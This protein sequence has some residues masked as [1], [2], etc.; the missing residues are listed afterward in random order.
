MD[1][2]EPDYVIPKLIEIIPQLRAR[3]IEMMDYIWSEINKLISYSI[4]PKFIVY[5]LPNS[6]A[7]RSFESGNLLNYHHKYAMRLCYNAQE[8]IWQNSIDEVKQ[9]IKVHPNIGKFLLPPCTLRLLGKK[10]PICPEGKRF[11]GIKVW[12][13]NINDYS[14]VL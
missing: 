12:K 6:V 11:C 1:L 7:I 2:S 4:N 9:I 13:L 14:R 10:Y 5:L 3:F 8:E